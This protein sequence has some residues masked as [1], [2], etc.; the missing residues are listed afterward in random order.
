V[1]QYATVHSHHPAL[2]RAVFAAACS[3]LLA[4]CASVSLPGRAP[5]PL[6][7]D[8]ARVEISDV[9][10][11]EITPRMQRFLDQYVTGYESSDMRRELL[12]LALMD[13]SMLGFH[14]DARR[15]FTAR[16]AFETRSGNCI[17]FA[18]LFVALAREAGLNARFHEV[19]IPPE[20]SREDETL[21]VTRHINV[22]VSSPQ[23]YYQVDISKEDLRRVMRKRILGDR[24]ALALYYNNLAM[25]ALFDSDLATA[26]AYLVKAIETAPRLADAWSN[27]GVVLSRNG[28]RDDAET[29][30]LTA[31]GI[32]GSERSAMVNLYGLYMAQERH[33]EAE[34]LRRQVER[35]RRENPY[36][37]LALSDRALE[38]RK[39]EESISLLSRAIE[40]KEDEHLLHF[41]MARTQYLSGREDEAESSLLRA[42]EL[43]P[44]YLRENYSRPLRELVL[45]ADAAGLR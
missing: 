34:A 1:F 21:I 42:R 13:T 29:A 44:E 22:A 18:S 2:L 5:P 27:L 8:H 30:Y 31:L 28:Q 17:A 19:L 33:Q 15:T 20:W 4:A 45:T 6:L 41:A 24:E 11:L 38:E 32:D 10:L 37:L 40:K 12:T 36:Y 9:D 35:Y 16:Q 7:G 14:Y 3:A 39:F 25:E 43:A 23:G 26:H